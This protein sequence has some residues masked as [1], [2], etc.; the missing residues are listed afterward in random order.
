MLVIAMLAVVGYVVAFVPARLTH[1]CIGG[2]RRTLWTGIGHREQWLRAVRLSY[3]AF[4]WPSLAVAIGW[5]TSRTRGSLVE[6]REQMRA[7][8]HP[9]R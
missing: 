3:F 8:E 7:T 9:K 2:F 5:R 1:L 6:L 4:G